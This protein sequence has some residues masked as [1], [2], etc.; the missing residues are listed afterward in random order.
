MVDGNSDGSVADWGMVVSARNFHKRGFETTSAYMW[1]VAGGLAGNRGSEC[2]LCHLARALLSLRL[3]FARPR[4]ILTNVIVLHF[5]FA[6]KSG[7]LGR[8]PK[9]IS[10]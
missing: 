7:M 1:A 8:G 3:L 5:N 6:S 2:M 4:E 10:A 9:D